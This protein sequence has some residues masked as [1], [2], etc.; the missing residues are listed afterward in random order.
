MPPASTDLKDSRQKAA[1]AAFVE[2]AG[3]LLPPK[4]LSPLRPM[5]MRVYRDDTATN[6]SLRS[7][8]GAHTPVNRPLMSAG[9]RQQLQRQVEMPRASEKTMLIS[10]RNKVS[11]QCSVDIQDRTTLKDSR[12]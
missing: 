11:N 12:F 1:A 5:S 7:R 10:D 2:R 3:G 9:P 4:A 6:L 8:S